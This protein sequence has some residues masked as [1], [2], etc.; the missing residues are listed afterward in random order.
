MLRVS[1]LGAGRM[2]REVIGEIAS[3]DDLEL[4]GV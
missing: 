3:A 2:G 4:A 1:V